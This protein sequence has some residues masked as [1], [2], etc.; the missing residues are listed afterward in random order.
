MALQD[1]PCGVCGGSR[2]TRVYHATIAGDGAGAKAYYSSSRARAGYLPIVRCLDCG[3]LMTNPRDDEATVRSVYRGLED[4]S[5]DAESQN[6]SLSAREYVHMVR[7]YNEKPNTL[8]DVGC[9]TGFFVASAAAQG[10]RVT[11]VDPSE[12]SIAEARRRA[13]Q[14]EFIQGVIE[15]LDFE[16]HAFDVIT[17]WDVLEHVTSPTDVL[18][19]LHRW[20]AP[21]GLLF[22]NVPNEA[23]PVAQAMGRHWVLLLRE[24]LW[25]FSPATAKRL[26]ESCG[27]TIVGVRPHRVRF[28]LLNILLRASQYG[29]LVGETASRM[30]RL[31]WMRRISLRF[32]VGEMTVV[33]RPTQAQRCHET[34]RTSQSDPSD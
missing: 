33:A 4:L 8:L 30:A 26:F 1:F 15:E 14:C 29:G 3:L 31:S 21:Q 18:R 7:Q 16:L 24:H 28:S 20:L 22:V 5:Y 13:P 23:S 2:F 32:P 10:W 11:G 12:W 17:L 27:F 34:Q 19:R 6:R 9:A 25:Y